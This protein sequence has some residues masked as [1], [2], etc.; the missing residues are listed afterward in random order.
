M[1]V[2]LLLERTGEDKVYLEEWDDGT[3][4]LPV[5]EVGSPEKR[6]R[7][8][9]EV[10]AALAVGYLSSLAQYPLAHF[11]DDVRAYHATFSESWPTERRW[12]TV[13]LE[14]VVDVVAPKWREWLVGPIAGLRR[15]RARNLVASRHDATGATGEERG[16]PP[17]RSPE[18]FLDF[19]LEGVGSADLVFVQ[20]A[21]VFV[22]N[23]DFLSDSFRSLVSA[24]VA[25]RS[26][27]D[28][29]TFTLNGEPGRWQVTLRRLD[30]WPWLM[31]VFD[32][33]QRAF[34]PGL[35]LKPLFRGQTT[36]D[37]FCAEVLAAADALL[38]FH[39]ED[40]Y[41]RC[42][43]MYPFPRAEVE[44]LRGL[45]SGDSRRS[46]RW[47]AQAADPSGTVATAPGTALG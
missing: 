44:A 26:G 9:R 12:R 33:N 25:L 17:G 11:D 4:H 43:Y 13:P 32:G 27:V 34:G 15:G 28:A 29:V 20:G 8:E 14:H 10:E 5:V 22:C 37:A 36:L 45:M 16:G 47:D 31:V 24:C 7:W 2:A 19:R 21:E 41:W 46:R 23:H 18:L 42:W 38:R 35:R 1:R 6:D 3:L 30:T 39:G 40:G